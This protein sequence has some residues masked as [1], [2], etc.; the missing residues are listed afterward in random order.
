[1]QL[2]SSHKQIG[3]NAVLRSF[4]LR[5]PIFVYAFHTYSEAVHT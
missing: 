3:L 2:S 4:F 1:M 5:F